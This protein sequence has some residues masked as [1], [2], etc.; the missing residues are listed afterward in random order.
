M[1]W[2]Y[3]TLGDYLVSH[4]FIAQIFIVTLMIGGAFLVLIPK[5]F[6]AYLTWKVNHKPTQFSLAVILGAFSFISLATTYPMFLSE[7]TKIGGSFFSNLLLYGALILFMLYF[8]L[9]KMLLYYQK[10]KVKK[11]A[12]V[13]SLLVFFAFLSFYCVSVFLVLILNPAISSAR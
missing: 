7:V 5:T 10:L 4:V 13:F 12:S 1:D 11:T 9:P 3:S 2:F 6:Q 8:S